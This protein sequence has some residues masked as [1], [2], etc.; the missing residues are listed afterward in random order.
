MTSSDIR[1]SS[2]FWREERGRKKRQKGLYKE[3]SVDKEEKEENKNMTGREIEIDGGALDE[4]GGV[5]Q[6]LIH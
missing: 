4:M 6:V 5:L 3:S 1:T 2:L